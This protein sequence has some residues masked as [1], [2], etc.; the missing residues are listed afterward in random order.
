MA[1]VWEDPHMN[2]NS[3]QRTLLSVVGAAA[4]LAGVAACGGSG[5]ADGSSAEAPPIRYQTLS[6]TV[7]LPD[8]ADALGLLDDFELQRLGDV[9]GGPESLQAL[10]T[11]QVDLATSFSGA[12]IKV[13]STGVPITAVIS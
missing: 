7:N 13:I 9:Q 2:F 3:L 5:A 10:A 6:G 12:T 11:D 1:T 4:L 8:L